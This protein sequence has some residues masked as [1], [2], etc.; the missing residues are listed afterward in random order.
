[1][2]TVSEHQPLYVEGELSMPAVANIVLADAQ[3]TPVN[4]TFIPLGPDTSGVWWFEDQ[5]S[6]S[7]EIG[8]NRISVELKRP[9]NPAPGQSSSSRLS[10][11]KIGIHTPKLETLGNTSAGLTPPATIAYIPRSTHEFMLPERGTLQDRKDLRK[12]AEKVLADANIVSV[13]EQ[14]QS[15][16]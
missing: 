15:Y 12:Y 1:V 13:I 2:L 4:H 8:W 11:V 5:N 14:L 7:A 16:F 9:R 6:G 3:A 10:R